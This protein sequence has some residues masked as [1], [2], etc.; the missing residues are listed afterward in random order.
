MLSSRRR[1]LA[2]FVLVATADLSGQ[3][4]V[5]HGLGY[6]G[7]DYVRIFESG[8]SAVP[9]STV[10]RPVT[11]FINDQAND[12][13]FHD[14][15]ATFRAMNILYAFASAVILAGLCRR[16]GASPAAT[17]V[18]IVNLFLCISTAKMFAFYPVLVDLGA[19]AFMAASVWAIVVG[20]RGRLS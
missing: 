11:L 18:L 7:Q 4:P 16:Y 6:D 8:F 17:A 20:R 1:S 5:N 14:P 9:V 2:N 15:L 3:I 12:R 13:Y 10:L 19:Y